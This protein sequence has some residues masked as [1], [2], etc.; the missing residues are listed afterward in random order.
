MAL[1]TFA[2]LSYLFSVNIIIDIGNTLTKLAVC[3]RG[4]VVERIVLAGF[5]LSLIWSFIGQYPQVRK[6]IVSNVSNNIKWDSFDFPFLELDSKT[7]LPFKNA[8]ETPETL[9]KDRIALAAAASLLYPKENCL[10]IDAGTCITYDFIDKE[11]IYHG[12]GISPGLQMR[13]NAL[14]HFTA[15][16]PQ[17]PYRPGFA[18]VGK[19]TDESIL[20]GVAGG[21]KREVKATIEEY[22]ER[23]RSVTAIIT[24]GDAFL[25]EDLTKSS[26]FAP[27]DFLLTGLNHILE[28]NAER[29]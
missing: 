11:N 10:I 1:V 23:Y 27:P 6:G 18:L 19:S 17:V 29:L 4:N 22:K 5:D 21:I 2:A 26:I 14:H 24:G 16:L 3:E 12:G 13:L 7:P 15:R 20:S 9:G 25:F 8:Y 28:Y